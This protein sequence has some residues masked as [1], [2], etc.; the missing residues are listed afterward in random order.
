MRIF[1]LVIYFF[2]IFKASFGYSSN[3]TTGYFECKIKGVNLNSIKEGLHEEYK[4]FEND[5]SKNDKLIIK[6]KHTNKIENSWSSQSPFYL[7]LKRTLS[8]P[9]NSISFFNRFNAGQTIVRGFDI[10]PNTETIKGEGAN[11]VGIALKPN[12]DGTRTKFKFNRINNGEVTV[13]F[14]NKG[15]NCSNPNNFNCI[16]EDRT[17]L[18]GA[19]SRNITFSENYISASEYSRHIYLKRY[20]KDDW[21]GMYSSF[22]IRGS[23]DAI[24]SYNFSF[25]CRHKI[26]QLEKIRKKIIKIRSQ[27]NLNLPK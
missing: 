17:E 24:N 19:G 26:D 27:I 5:F 23:E 7:V 15:E 4:G 25:D 16:T 2:L 12:P 13:K 8:D 3:T 20:H 22:N 14:A 1:K 21:N 11:S 10:I 9:D 18:I 6:Y